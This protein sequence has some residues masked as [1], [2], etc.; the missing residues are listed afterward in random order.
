MGILRDENLFHFLLFYYRLS[1]E[2]FHKLA[3][4]YP[5]LHQKVEILALE[6][7]DEILFNEEREKNRAKVGYKPIN[8][9]R[10]LAD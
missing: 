9:P 2:D 4:A 10:Y 1:K 6:R 5:D 8:K 3:V 7:I